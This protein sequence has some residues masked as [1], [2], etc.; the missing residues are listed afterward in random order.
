MLFSRDWGIITI[1]VETVDFSFAMFVEN[2]AEG[3]LIDHV[4]QEFF[5]GPMQDLFIGDDF[6]EFFVEG[7]GAMIACFAVLHFRQKNG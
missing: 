5:E 4:V 6:M 2:D 7:E 3:D 1:S